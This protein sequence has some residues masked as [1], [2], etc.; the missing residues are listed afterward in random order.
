MLL[1][2]E[3]CGSKLSSDAKFCENCGIEISQNDGGVDLIRDRKPNLTFFE[4]NEWKFSFKNFSH[5][6]SLTTGIILVNTTG[7]SSDYLECFEKKLQ[8]YIDFSINR[9]TVYFVL[10][11]A[12]QKVVP[13]ANPNDLMSVIETLKY[14]YNYNVPDFLMIIGDRNSVPSVKWENPLDD[15]DD[16]VD[17]DLC[18]FTL[19]IESP[20]KKIPE[21]FYACPARIPAS[22]QTG[23]SQA[24]DY[25]DNVMNNRNLE[26]DVKAVTLSAREWINVSMLNFEFACNDIYACPPNSFLQNENVSSI[27]NKE[28]Y[29]LLCFNLHGSQS[30]DYWV[31]GDGTPGYSPDCLPSGYNEYIICTE[32]CYGAKPIIR[33]NGNQSTLVAALQNGCIAFCGSTQIAYGTPDS[34]LCIGEKPSAADILVGSF[35]KF[36]YA[37]MTTGA[38][39]LQAVYNL[40]NDSKFV[41]AEDIKTLASFALYGDPSLCLAQN[42][43]EKT[44]KNEMGAIKNSEALSGR[45]RLRF[46]TFPNVRLMINRRI[47]DVSTKIQNTISGCLNAHFKEFINISPDYY[48]LSEGRGY[49]ATFKKKNKTIGNCLN[50]YVDSHGSICKIYISK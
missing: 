8:K 4:S 48:E 10:N 49:K 40:L 21:R 9:G 6:N 17:S 24:C 39:Y 26:I 44:E 45:R 27:A 3:N 50:I 33:N 15:F 14:I 12:T 46:A 23:F 25:F 34:A 20:F 13:G 29:N 22:L 32:A 28:D 31:S 5:Y 1:F 11:M 38:A 16:F 19:D 43:G 37:R 35:A 47:F 2:C 30:F 36:V 41:H 42:V 7:C 18:Y